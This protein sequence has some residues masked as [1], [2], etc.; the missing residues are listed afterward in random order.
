MSK[1][2]WVEWIG[3]WGSGKT[4][5]INKLSERLELSG[6]EVTTT[7]RFFEK[8]RPQKIYDL[9][10]SS[11][12][13]PIL[14]VKFFF[15]FIPIYLRAYIDRR[16]IIKAELRSFFSCYIARLSMIGN[17][18]PI[19]WEGE[20]HLLPILDLTENTTD[21]LL[22]HLLAINNKKLNVFVIMKIDIETAKVRLMRDLEEAKNIRF[23]PEESE[24][25]L[26]FLQRFNSNQEYLVKGLKDRAEIV[27][28]VSD[29]IKELED[30][31]LS[32]IN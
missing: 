32:K 27:Y 24:L 30:F 12:Y 2:I 5:S 14:L 15:I 3:L 21:K 20:T 26:N 4:T 28:E 7:K 29:N 10:K 31:L 16:A 13:T 18:N 11:P 6:Y 17:E 22:N 8:S 9:A 23:A 19:L 25:Y 1:K